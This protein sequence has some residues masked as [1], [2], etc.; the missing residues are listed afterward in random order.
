MDFYRVIAV[1]QIGSRSFEAR[2]AGP[3]TPGSGVCYWFAKRDEVQPFVDNLNQA[4]REAKRIGAMRRT[5]V[6]TTLRA[7]SRA[8]ARTAHAA[9]G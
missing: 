9:C 4:F 6:R 2:I 5:R 7:T 8:A 3:G 1:I